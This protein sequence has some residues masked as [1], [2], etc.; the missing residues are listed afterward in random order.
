MTINEAIEL[1]LEELRKAEKRHPGWPD[2]PVYGVAILNE[3]S[4]EATKEAL[5][6]S[7]GVDGAKERFVME[8]AQ[9][10][11]MAIRNLIHLSRL[12]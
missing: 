7:F 11:A 5:D 8:L 3:E 4:G 6:I 2:D 1:I 10:G 9:T 12:E